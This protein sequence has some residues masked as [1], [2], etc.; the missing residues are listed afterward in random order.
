M[1]VRIFTQDDVRQLLK[2]PRAIELMR[3]A[4]AALSAGRIESPIRTT[5]TNDHGTVLYKPAWSAA[6]S[7]FCAKVVSVFPGNA[8]KGLPVTPGIIVLNDGQTGMPVGL[9][10][11]GFLTSL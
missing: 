4:F 7:L 5:L 10:E 11:A 6:H 9:L 1:D 2:M 8:D 3:D